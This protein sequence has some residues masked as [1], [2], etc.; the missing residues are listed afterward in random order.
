MCNLFIILLQF[1]DQVVFSFRDERQI[2]SQKQHK[3][4]DANRQSEALREDY[5]KQITELEQKMHEAQVSRF[6]TRRERQLV[7][8][9]EQLKQHFP[10]MWVPLLLLPDK[11]SWPLEAIV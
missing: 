2:L 3:I 8:T 10:G 4:S 1:L 6:Q 9:V 5:V 11:Y 7:E